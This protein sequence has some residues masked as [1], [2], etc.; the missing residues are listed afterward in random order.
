MCVALVEN[1]YLLLVILVQSILPI[2]T[3]TTKAKLMENSESTTL[4]Y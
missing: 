2:D 4:A 1:V 3:L